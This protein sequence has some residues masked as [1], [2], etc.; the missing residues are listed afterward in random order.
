M[1][2]EEDPST[3]SNYNSRRTTKA[4]VPSTSSNYNSRVSAMV[5]KK[6]NA[7]SNKPGCI[8]T[9]QNGIKSK[10]I[11]NKIGLKCVVSCKD[12]ILKYLRIKIVLIQ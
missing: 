4:S 3:S 10:L 5:A 11:D 9:V 6:T 8:S 2:N 1:E 7:T 12:I